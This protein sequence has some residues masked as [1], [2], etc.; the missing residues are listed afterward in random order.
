MYGYKQKCWLFPFVLGI[1][2]LRQVVGLC[3]RGH[4]YMYTCIHYIHVHNV[5]IMYTLNLQIFFLV[6]LVIS[7]ELIKDSLH[8]VFL[9]NP[10]YT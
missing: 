3:M 9:L 4:I 2:L 10:A 7:D 8:Y 6:T 5:Y 1:L